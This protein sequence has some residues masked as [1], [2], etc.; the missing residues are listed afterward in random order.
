MALLRNAVDEGRRDLTQFRAADALDALH[1]REDFKKLLA[2]LD[3]PSPDR[4][5]K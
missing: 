4:P 5:K 2:E 1:E 3:K